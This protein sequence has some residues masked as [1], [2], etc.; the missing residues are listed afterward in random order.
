M[1]TVLLS[2]NI[3]C[4]SVTRFQDIARHDKHLCTYASITEFKGAYKLWTDL[5]FNV[6]FFI[7]KCLF[8]PSRR[9]EREI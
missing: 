5:D 2:H 4:Y 3:L 1:D 6:M 9:D 8:A 7:E